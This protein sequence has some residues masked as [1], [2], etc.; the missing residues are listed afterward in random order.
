MGFPN[1]WGQARCG[2]QAVETAPERPP[3]CVGHETRRR[4]LRG[5]LPTGCPV[6][7]RLQPAEA[8]FADARERIP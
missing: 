5:M 4:G 3:G 7:T 2:T 1:D 6:G 8:G